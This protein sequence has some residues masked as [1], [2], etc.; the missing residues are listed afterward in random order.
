MEMA[1]PTQQSRAWWKESSVYQVYPASFQDSNGSGVGDLKGIIS[2]VD[3]LKN[4]GVDI[5]WLS[6]IFDSPQI[7]MGYDISDYN[8]IYPPYGD[9]ADVD[10]LK[11]KL[12]ERGMKLVLDLVMN[13]TSDQHRWFKESRKSK[14][15]PF[16]DWY[17]WKPPKYDAQGNRQP[18]NNWKGHFQG[19]AWE[20]DEQ[21]D[22]YY[23]HLFCTEQPD[24]NWE[25]PAVRKAAH[26][27]MRFWLD[28][29][30]DGFRIDVINFISKDQ[31]FPDS[32]KTVLP[33]SEFYAAGPRLHEYLKELGAIL[34]EYDAFS[35]GE[36]PCVHD[37]QQL[38]KAVRSDRGELSMIFHFELM[39]ID[40]GPG[41]K[42]SP[43]E[44][45]LSELKETTNKWQ[46][47]MYDNDGWNALYLE[48]HDQPRSVSRFANDSPEHR[49]ASAK[50]IAIFL[51]FQAGT[52]FV[53][54]GQEIGMT[55]VPEDWPME[56]YKDVDCLNHWSLFKDTADEKTKEELKRNYQK[57][58]RDNARTP[59][60]WDST[61]NAGFTSG[62]EPWMR[63]NDN[64]QAINAA[65]QVSDP[66]SVYHSWR[67]VLE[68]RK[69][70][71]DIFVYGDFGL[72]DEPNERVFAYKRIAGD[73]AAALIA[74]NFSAD[75]VSWGFEGKAKEV[76]V[77]SGGKS[78][79]DVS[80][81]E[82]SL[83]PYEAIAM[84][85]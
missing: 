71:K 11:D 75:R 40:H 59:M 85:L 10:T 42:F 39:D 52:P 64:Y 79:E 35:V 63:V 24:L 1:N 18:P 51:G 31:S 15:N 14:D 57:K 33:G 76:L 56:E 29:G 45:K 43:K 27:V 13:H 54:Q 82:I 16:R 66:N 23:L 8:K 62:N 9:I 38:I 6:P 81:G 74:C 21:T 22:E 50:L 70:L 36:M 72:V 41:G 69:E 67:Q 44:W 2:R 12:H 37:E 68:K 58:S 3:Y 30:C 77:S 28:R 5:V 55:N 53:Y 7:D 48:N 47:F 26:D 78:L 84:L 46:R 19:S 34:K 17:I 4:L 60:Q 61:P 25:N 20:Y 80:S 65:A 73:G 32:D 83:G 49:A